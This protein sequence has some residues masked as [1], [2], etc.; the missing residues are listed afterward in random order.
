MKL[1][2]EHPTS[3]WP[4]STDYTVHLIDHDSGEPLCY[5][6]KFITE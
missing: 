4:L 6:L 1:S 2:E 3:R 5:E